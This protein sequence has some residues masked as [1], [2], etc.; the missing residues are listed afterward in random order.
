M[1]DARHSFLGSALRF[2]VAGGAN[3]VV[4]GALL[5]LLTLVMDPQIAYTLVFAVGIVISTVLADRFVYGIRLGTKG[6]VSYVALYVVVYLVGLLAVHLWTAS[7]RPALA[8]GLVVVIT[9]PL[10]FLGG[11]L[12][13][14]YVAKR[15]PDSSEP[16][17]TLQEA[18]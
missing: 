4:T 15:R 3:T 1:S 6:I 10:T 16:I 9:A 7:G 8:S 14:R 2:I 13:T 18:S 11:R 12:I 5:S 17:V